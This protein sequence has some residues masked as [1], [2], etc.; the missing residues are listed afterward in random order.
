MRSYVYTYISDIGEGGEFHFK[1]ICIWVSRLCH[2]DQ[3]CVVDEDVVFVVG[4]AD[5]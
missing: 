4:K 1:D 2:F 5:L 3:V